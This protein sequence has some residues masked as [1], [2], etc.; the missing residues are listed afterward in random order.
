P[1]FRISRIIDEMNANFRTLI[2]EYPSGMKVNAL[3]AGKN[4]GV[5]DEYVAVGNGT[6][7]I[8]DVLSRT[9]LDGKK[10]GSAS[11]MFNELKK[12][13]VIKEN[14]METRVHFKYTA[15]DVVNYFS[16]NKLDVVLLTNPDAFLAIA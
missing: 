3:V 12:C 16:A 8:A 6:A 4:Y 15:D 1:Y 14:Q 10:A 13:Q 2:G 11:P 5:R 9:L 7:E